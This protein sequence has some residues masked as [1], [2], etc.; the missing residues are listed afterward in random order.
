MLLI[1]WSRSWSVSSFGQVIKNSDQNLI[2]YYNTHSFKIW[3][4]S[5]LKSGWIKKKQGKKNSV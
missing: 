1:G 2:E 3:F 5:E 4:G